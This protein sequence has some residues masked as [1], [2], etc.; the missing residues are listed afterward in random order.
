M[1]AVWAF[2]A[3]GEGVGYRRRFRRDSCPANIIPIEPR[4]ASTREITP[5]PVP[6]VSALVLR[7]DFRCLVDVLGFRNR[8]DL[9]WTL[10]ND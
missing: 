5:M 9:L 1:S 2:A 4:V 8:S 10:F 7:L 3:F 6:V